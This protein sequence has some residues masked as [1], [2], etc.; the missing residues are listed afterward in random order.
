MDPVQA[1]TR[2]DDRPVLLISGGRDSS[3]G[4]N[5]ASDLRDA[6]IEAGS[7]AELHVCEAAGHA[8]SDTSCPEDYPGWVLGFLERSLAPPS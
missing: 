8:E 2:L 7:P 1:I 3:I 5:D 4:P 6:A